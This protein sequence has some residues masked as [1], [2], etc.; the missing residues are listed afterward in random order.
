MGA[1]SSDQNNGVTLAALWTFLQR[2]QQSVTTYVPSARSQEVKLPPS[3]AGTVSSN[4]NTSKKGLEQAMVRASLLVLIQHSVVSVRRKPRPTNTALNSKRMAT[5]PYVY[6][7]HPERAVRLGGCRYARYV[8]YMKRALQDSTAATVIESLL[9]HGRL[10]TIELVLQTV[11]QQ[12][13]EAASSTTTA[14][15]SNTSSTIQHHKYTARETIVDALAK[16]VRGGFVEQAPSIP[17]PESTDPD[18]G[19]T[20]FDPAS[21]PAI[22]ARSTEEPPPAK[23]VKLELPEPETESNKAATTL[24]DG[25][26]EDPAVVQLLRSNAHYKSTLPIDTAWRVNQAMFHDSIRALRLGRLVAELYNHRVRW[27]GSLVTGALKY[28]AHLDH[29]VTATR[30]NVAA[31]GGASSTEAATS[32]SSGSAM[33]A[34]G[35][36]DTGFFTANDVLKYLPKSVVQSIETEATKTGLTTVQIMHKAF[37]D[38][39]NLRHPTIVVRRVGDDSFEIAH[40][41]L[42][43]YLRRR[44]IH[45]V[46]VDR[47]GQVAARIIE[48]LWRQGWLESDHLANTAM[49]PAKETRTI[50]H[51]L[52]RSRYIELFQLSTSNSSKHYNHNSSI[53]LWCVHPDRIR[54]RVVDNVLLATRNLNV[55][56]Q[57]ESQVVGR[58]WIERAQRQTQEDENEHE[59]DKVNYQ[60]FCLGL[61][62]IDVALHQ[63]DETMLALADF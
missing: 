29:V 60:K 22:H 55:R 23:K 59:T 48:V 35:P 25:G 10:R 4:N 13:Q 20:E 58:E 56:R 57:H 63:L 18:A 7:Y 6:R 40:A 34:V 1:S 28:R 15:E 38:L 14:E 50:L 44:I 12:Q 11:Q 32:G 27:S 39:S 62:R 5:T 47:H 9:L 36:S 3:I 46:I 61:E 2:K 24:T 16:L 45:Q 30:P 41:A 43:E 17:L 19:E 52:Y 33:P 37:L 21:T 8:D 42:L 26:G 31:S 53:Y 54:Q 49:V 51:E